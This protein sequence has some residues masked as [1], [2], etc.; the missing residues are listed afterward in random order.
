VTGDFA[1]MFNLHIHR[2]QLEDRG[3]YMCQINTDPMMQQVAR[4]SLSLIVHQFK[5][6]RVESTVRRF[7]WILT[8]QSCG[9][10]A[11]PMP[12]DMIVYFLKRLGAY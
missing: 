5:E 11:P 1:S 2:V 4:T 9:L 7:N 8:C 6:R 12:Y 10:A 3:H